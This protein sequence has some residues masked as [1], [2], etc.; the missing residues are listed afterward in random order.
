MFTN[1]KLSNLISILFVQVT[2]FENNFLEQ[3]EDGGVER[4]LLANLTRCVF[5]LFEFHQDK[6]SASLTS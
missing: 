3:T 6:T 4:Y 1:I 5:F 2:S